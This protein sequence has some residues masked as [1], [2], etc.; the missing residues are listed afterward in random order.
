MK[1]PKYSWAAL[2]LTLVL[3]CFFLGEFTSPH[4]LMFLD[5]PRRMLSR[6]LRKREER[7][8]ASPWGAPSALTAFPRRFCFHTLLGMNS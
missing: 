3:P 7:A 5:Y 2:G 6:R 8:G 4:S 1:I